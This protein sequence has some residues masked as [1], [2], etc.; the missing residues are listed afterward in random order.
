MEP[1]KGQCISSVQKGQQWRAQNN[2]RIT[3]HM[4]TS[5]SYSSILFLKPKLKIL[6]SFTTCIDIIQKVTLDFLIYRYHTQLL[7][8]SQLYMS[9]SHMDS[10]HSCACILSSLTCTNVRRAMFGVLY[11]L[12]SYMKCCWLKALGEERVRGL[13]KDNI[14]F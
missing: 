9:L 10:S 5:Y 14:V 1:I 13:G 12:F 11:N 4:S 6:L 3:F 2:G 7:N 8:L